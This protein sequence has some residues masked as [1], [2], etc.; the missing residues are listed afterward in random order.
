M[1]CA[2]LRFA[3]N[4]L[5]DAEQAYAKTF[6]SPPPEYIEGDRY[7]GCHER[8]RLVTRAIRTGTPLQE[9]ELGKKLLQLE[10]EYA[11]NL[12]G[13]P[14]EGVLWHENGEE[15]L[16]QRIAIL[17]ESLR[18]GKRRLMVEYGMGDDFPEHDAV[19]HLSFGNRRKLWLDHHGNV[20]W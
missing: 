20:L 7:G 15:S 3:M 19:S 18:L 11:R 8:S 14:Q 12:G 6:G 17:E 2:T 4:N 16:V 1:S 9:S 5:E 13:T 10:V